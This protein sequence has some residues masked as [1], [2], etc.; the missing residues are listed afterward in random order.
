MPAWDPGGAFAWP[1]NRPIEPAMF[2]PVVIGDPRL[3][4]DRWWE[5]QEERERA[6]REQA[7]RDEAERLT[8]PAAPNSD[9]WK[10]AEG[11]ARMRAARP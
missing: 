6:A 9:W 10:T 4:T 5:V 3:T 1:P 7:E 8:K 11:T 2:A